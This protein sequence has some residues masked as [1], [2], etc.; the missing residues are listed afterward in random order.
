MELNA[1]KYNAIYD[2]IA[3]TEAINRDEL[4]LIEILNIKY[5]TMDIVTWAIKFIKK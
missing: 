3:I 2:N 4:L 1:N 5:I